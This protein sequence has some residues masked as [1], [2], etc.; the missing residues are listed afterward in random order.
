MTLII[1]NLYVSCSN[2]KIPLDNHSK[3]IG[4]LQKMKELLESFDQGLG[5]TFCIPNID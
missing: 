2:T 3:V 4:S 1:N 5:V